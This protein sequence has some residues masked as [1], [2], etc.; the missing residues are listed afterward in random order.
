M[1]D[2]DAWEVRIRV[3]V[4]RWALAIA[5]ASLVVGGI[6]VGHLLVENA[7]CMIGIRASC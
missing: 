3:R 6:L 4:D 7:A 2:G 1:R 5:V